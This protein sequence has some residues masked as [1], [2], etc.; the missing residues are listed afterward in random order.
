MLGGDLSVIETLCSPSPA[1]NGW[2]NGPTRWF[3]MTPARSSAL[4]FRRDSLSWTQAI[5]ALRTAEERMRFAMEAAG[6]GIWD[7]DYVSG[8]V[9]WSETLEAHNGLEAGT[10]GGTFE[11]F[12]ERIHPDDRQTVLETIAQ[13]KRSGADFSFLCRSLRPDGAVRWLSHAGRIHIGAHG[14]AVRGVGISL[15]VTER[16]TLEA[17]YSKPRDGSHRRLAGEWAHDFNNMLTVIL[18]YCELLLGGPRRGR[19]PPCGHRGNSESGASAA[20]LTRQL[21]AFSRK[22]SS[23]RRSRPERVVGEMR[24]MARAPDRGR[25][26]GRPRPRVAPGLVKADR[27][28]TWRIVV[29]LVVNARDHASRRHPDDRNRQRNLDEPRRRRKAA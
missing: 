4:Q 7:I 10:F 24:A 14:E 16:R 23:S 28:H 6:V 9:R 27:G 25:R 21:L 22:K 1:R 17:Q 5:G 3:A 20:A 8:V 12:I 18:G 11:A 15:D 2:S 26:C 19:P 29:N 13:A